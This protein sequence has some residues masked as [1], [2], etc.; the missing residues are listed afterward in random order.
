VQG[1]EKEIYDTLSSQS[2]ERCL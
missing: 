1:N 2:F